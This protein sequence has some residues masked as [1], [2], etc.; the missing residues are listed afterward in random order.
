[1]LDGSDLRDKGLSMSR[2]GYDVGASRGRGARRRLS[3][4]IHMSK[5]RRDRVDRLCAQLPKIRYQ[6]AE[7]GIP[8]TH[9]HIRRAAVQFFMAGAWLTHPTRKVQ[10][11]WASYADEALAR[12]C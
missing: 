4:P 3:D 10:E 12:G 5:K 7:A 9:V 11:V 1:V 2:W 8:P 6:L